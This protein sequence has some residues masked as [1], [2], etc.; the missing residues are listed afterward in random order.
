MSASIENHLVRSGTVCNGLALVVGKPFLQTS[1]HLREDLVEAAGFY[2]D[3][4]KEYYLWLDKVAGEIFT[5]LRL[6]AV[7]DEG[8]LDRLNSELSAKRNL[9]VYKFMGKIP[10]Q[11]YGRFSDKMKETYLKYSRKAFH[12]DYVISFA[13]R[14]FKDDHWWEEMCQISTVELPDKAKYYLRECL[15]CYLVGAFDASVVMAGRATEFALKE[16]L[17]R[18]GLPFN[19]GDALHII[20]D[21][22]KRS[23]GIDQIPR[24]TQLMNKIEELVRAYRNT[25]AH[26]NPQTASKNEA[27]MLFASAKVVCDSLAGSMK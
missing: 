26:D 27:E 23:F 12:G 2:S 21:R 9:A 5:S 25:T 6:A 19:E 22:F 1:C 10:S 14:K 24:E 3:S 8:F 13:L 4:K 7:S 17:R 16:N 18:R 15:K 20:W 11:H